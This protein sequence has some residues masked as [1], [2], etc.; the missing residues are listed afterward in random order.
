MDH[1]TISA[2]CVRVDARTGILELIVRMLVRKDILAQTVPGHVH[3]TVNLT[4]VETRTDGVL[5][6]LQDGPVIIVQQD[7]I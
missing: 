1:V 4:H 3:L 5:H 2:E 7:A 6:V